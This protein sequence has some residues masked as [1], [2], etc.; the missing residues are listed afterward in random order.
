MIGPTA[1]T[2]RGAVELPHLDSS[3]Q[4]W[5]PLKQVCLLVAGDEINPTGSKTRCTGI[6]W[7]VRGSSVHSTTRPLLLAQ[8]RCVQAAH[9][10]T[11]SVR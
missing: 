1:N 3:D 10:Q 9:T 8:Q 4:V 6:S 11:L 7:Q 2:E 5:A